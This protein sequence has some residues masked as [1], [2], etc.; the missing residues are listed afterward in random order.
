MRG[1]TCVSSCSRYRSEWRVGRVGRLWG[2]GGRDVHG[3]HG[4]LLLHSH[5][6]GERQ[7]ITAVVHKV[8]IAPP[9]LNP[10]SARGFPVARESRELVFFLLSPILRLVPATIPASLVILLPCL[11]TSHAALARSSRLGFGQEGEHSFVGC[12][13]VKRTTSVSTV[14]PDVCVTGLPAGKRF[15]RGILTAGAFVVV[16]ERSWQVIYRDHASN[17]FCGVGQQDESL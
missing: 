13:S 2:G 1:K 4:R 8:T 5:H 7:V 14:E 9:P 15:I 17:F 3:V 11:S 10:F 16:A 6:V 12:V